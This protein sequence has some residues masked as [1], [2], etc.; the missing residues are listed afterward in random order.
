M[1]KDNDYHLDTG[2]LSTPH[3][4][5]VL[6]DNGYEDI[7]FK[8]LYQDTIPSWLYEVRKGATSIWEAWDCVKADG[9]LRKGMSFNH[10]AFGAVGEWLYR[11]IA[12]I[13]LDEESPGYKHII[14]SPHPGDGLTEAQAAHQS[15]YGEIRSLWK[16]SEGK[17]TYGITIPVNTTA[18]VHLPRAKIDE[19]SENNQ[20]LRN[21]EGVSKISHE[22][23]KV[24]L[25]VGSG[26]YEFRY[27]YV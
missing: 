23:G 14:L 13:G 17:M 19:I 24:T 15:P 16:L 3:L 1:I 7:A 4:C 2:F 25:E 9:T 21:A 22:V 18:T 10:Y 11:Y 12:G 27:T 5:Q 26:S 6:C 20:P 8:V